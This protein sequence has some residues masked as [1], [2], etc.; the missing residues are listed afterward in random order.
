MSELLVFSLS[1]QT[2]G[3]PLRQSRQQ[4]GWEPLVSAARVGKCWVTR[5]WEAI[6]I[7]VFY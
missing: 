3:N 6:I 1:G 5:M 7:L 2:V 4:I